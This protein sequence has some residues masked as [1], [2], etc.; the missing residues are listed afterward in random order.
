MYN[1]NN[2]SG[3]YHRYVN[4]VAGD[5]IK[6]SRNLNDGTIPERV[7]KK[8]QWYMVEALIMGEMLARLTEKQISERDKESLVYLGAIMALFDVFTDDFRF[9]N[10]RMMSILNTTFATAHPA[11]SFSDSAIEN[12]YQ[13]YLGKLL[14][15]I[16]KAYWNEVSKYLD[17]IKLQIESSKQYKGDATEDSVKKITIGKGGVAVL[18]FSVFL[19]QKDEQFKSALFE[20]G[21]LIQMMNDCQDLYKDTVAG[22]KTYAHFCHSFNEIFQRM[23]EQRII[24]FNSLISLELPDSEKSAFLFDLNA[25]FVVISYKLHLFAVA[26]SYNLDFNAIKTM[27]KKHF[28]INPFS[29]RAIAACTG[30]ILEFDYPELDTVN[31][32]KFEK[33]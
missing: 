10:E 13:I 21:G 27:D 5:I 33:G 12:V 28:R 16:D 29:P 31:V 18:I 3:S 4:K 26:C 32:F 30:R 17:I 15:T 9:D 8:I 1:A 23:N 25:M 11:A 2:T 19:G 6:V 20:T 14:L 24:A 7:F 22:I